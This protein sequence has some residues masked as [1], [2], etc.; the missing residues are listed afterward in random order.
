MLKNPFPINSFRNF[1]NKKIKNDLIININEIWTEK[2]YL[3]GLN[4]CINEVEK[5]FY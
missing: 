3:L 5:Y 4:R 2:K 1:H